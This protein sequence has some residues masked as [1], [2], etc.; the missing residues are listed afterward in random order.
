MFDLIVAGGTIVD[1]TGRSGYPADVGVVGEIIQAIGDLSRA[2]AVRR[3]D[4][5]EMTVSP[6][7]IDTHTHAEG[8][9]LVDPQHAN[10]VRQGITSPRAR[11]I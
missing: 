3:I 1:G 4:A 5:A 9:L 10:G 2:E 8:A 7:F 6:G 11:R